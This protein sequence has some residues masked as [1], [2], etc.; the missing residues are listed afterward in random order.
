VEHQN[1]PF[2]WAR[3]SSFSLPEIGVDKPD[4]LDYDES[5]ESYLGDKSC[6]SSSGVRKLLDNPRAFIAEAAG[7]L[8]DDETEEKDAYRFGSAAHMMILEPAKFRNM[9][10]IEPEFTGFTKEG[11]P[12]TQSAD[13]KLKRK[14]WYESL[15]PGALVVTQE[16]LHD[17]TYMVEALMEHPQASSLLRNGRP[18]VTG[19]FT[20]PETKVRCRIRPDY[21]T[22]DKEDKTYVIDIKTTRHEKIG[23]FATDVAKLQY[24]I[25]LAMYHDGIAQ[26]TGKQVEASAFIAL[27]KKPPYSV[28]VYW[29]NDKDLELGRAWYQY[30][31]KVFSRCVKNNDW[32]PAQGQ[33]QMLNMPNYI[34]NEPFPNFEWRDQK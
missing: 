19:R 27:T 31:L 15:A 17:L 18:E 7:Y 33:G 25:Q 8:K 14:T 20:H 9:Y 32:P 2:K 30:G 6:I 13:C 16:E 10:L 23:L 34:H 3:T 1:A 24:F 11:K 12:S 26:I 28:A 21:L 29:M 5:F 4:A 22:L